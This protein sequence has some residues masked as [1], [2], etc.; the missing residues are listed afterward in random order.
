MARAVTF[1]EIM[2]RLNPKLYERIVQADEFAV[3]YAGA[4][5]SVAVSLAQYGVDAAFVSKLPDTEVGQAA[6]NSLRRYGVD[7]R[8]IVRCQDR[9]GIY[10]VEKGAS[11]RPSRV[12]YDRA[13]SAISKAKRSDFDWGAIFAGADW[14]HFTGITPA[15]SPALVEICED[16]CKAAKGKGITISCD[17]NYRNKLWSREAA[18]EAMTKLM[19]YVDVC[20]A[21]EEDAK[22][23]FGIAAADTDVESG[24]LNRAGYE[25]VA[26]QLREMFGFKAVAFTLRESISANDNL[27]SGMLYDGEK[28]CYSPKHSIHIVD[29]LGGGDS[30]GAGLIYSLMNGYDTQRAINFAVAASCLKHSIEGDFNL[31]TVKEVESLAGGNASGRVQR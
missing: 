31:V 28:F 22:D 23:V 1:G 30:F 14:F 9:I 27:W 16:A 11:Q 5:A 12:I 20:I 6:I 8:G 13:D 2:M 24:K 15:L 26:R 25:S 21:N 4:E 18:R 17:L 19:R 10:F 29:R 7:T 3:T